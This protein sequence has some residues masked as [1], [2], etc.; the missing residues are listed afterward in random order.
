MATP[1]MV[2]VIASTARYRPNSWQRPGGEKA[3]WN[4]AREANIPGSALLLSDLIRR[5][6]SNFTKCTF[7]SD[8][9]S[10]A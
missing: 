3:V 6:L 5:P 9:S 7:D 4:G 10:A 8:L 1:L 2:G